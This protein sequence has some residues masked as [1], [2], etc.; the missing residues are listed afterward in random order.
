M[1]NVINGNVDAR[2]IYNYLEVK[3]RF[4]GWVTEALN[5]IDA[6][7]GKDFCRKN[8]KSTGGRPSIEYDLTIDCAKEICL[9]Q[10]SDKSK[11]LRRWLISLSNK[12]DAGLAF[13]SDQIES[14]IDLSKAMTLISIQENVEK[15]HFEVFNNK[16]SWHKYRA[17]LLGYSTND[18]IDAMMRV[19]KKHKS[20]RNSLIT[21]DAD[22]LIRVGVVDFMI[23]LGKT[24]EYAL[25]VGELCKTMSKKMELA[26][27]IW[28]D[29]KPN[30]LN[31]N[32]RE[33]NKVKSDFIDAKS[34]LIN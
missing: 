31:I 14:L 34:R 23:A 27:I 22:E 8:G 32:H 26:N 33:V 6:K 17:D 15:K 16:Y 19:N 9:T 3:S 7:E 10:R 29:T 24:Q 18:I 20:T 5:F 13:T 4:N 12:H 2:E 28:D 1:L 25:N 30:P 21:L 11:E